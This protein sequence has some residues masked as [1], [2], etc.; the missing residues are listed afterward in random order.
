MRVALL[1]V[2]DFLVEDGVY[3]TRVVLD[4]AMD[5]RDRLVGEI[6]GGTLKIREDG[7]FDVVRRMIVAYH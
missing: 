4:E 6:A 5:R 3:K 1:F 2:C 7:V